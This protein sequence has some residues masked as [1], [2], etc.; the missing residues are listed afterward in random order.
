MSSA[1]HMNSM[2]QGSV[3]DFPLDHFVMDEVQDFSSMFMSSGYT[4]A[5]SSWNTSS[6]VAMDQM[7]Y[8]ASCDQ[9]VSHFIVD[10]VDTFNKMFASA[11]SN[12]SIVTWNIINAKVIR[13]GATPFL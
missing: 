12:H 13:K 4:F 2:F 8:D 1:V 10:K 6:A 9:D 3:F 7:F 5:V 11:F